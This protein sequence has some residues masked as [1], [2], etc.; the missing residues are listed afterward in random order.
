M[1]RDAA[2]CT[3]VRALLTE[4]QAHATF[5]DAVADLA[6]ADRGRRPDALPYSVWELVEHLRRAQR[7]LLEYCRDPGYTMP[8]WPDAFWPEGPAP[9]DDAAWTESVAQVRADRDAMVGLVMD[10]S[11]DLYDTVPSHDEHTYL[12]SALLVAD[13]TAYHVGQIV[14]VR[15]SLGA[16]PPAGEA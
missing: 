11:V 12:R 4:P 7:D 5:D 8:D 2:L 15:R 16:W 14:A 1:D 3:H 9:P 6:P 13:H 10:E